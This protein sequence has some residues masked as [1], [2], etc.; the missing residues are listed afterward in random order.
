[1]FTEDQLEVPAEVKEQVTGLLTGA[2]IA[3]VT[4]APSNELSEAVPEILGPGEIIGLLAA[5]L[6]L[7]LMLGTVVA[8]AL[9]IGS[10]LVGVASACWPRWR[11]PGRVDM[12]SVTPVLGVMLGLAVGIDYSLFILNRHRHQL[13][14]GVEMHDSHR[15]GQR[16]R[17]VTPSS[18]P[19]RRSWSR[20]SPST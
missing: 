10:A 14:E 1:M 9:P 19:A 18:S 8:A 17:P 5:G 7:L 2:D 6:A 12:M 20:C 4:V 13:R 16:H 15:P 11:C 3:G